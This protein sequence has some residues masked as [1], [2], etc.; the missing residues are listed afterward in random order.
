MQSLTFDRFLEARGLLERTEVNDVAN[1]FWDAH[2]NLRHGNSS[3][4]RDAEVLD[5]LSGDTC[6]ETEEGRVWMIVPSRWVR[7]WLLFAHL[8]IS[9]DAPGPINMDSLLQRDDS[10][11]GGWRPKNTLL[12][13]GKGAEAAEKAA[14]AAGIFDK[15]GDKSSSSN[16]SGGK[17]AS[18]EDFPG[19]Y[20]RISLEAWVQLVDLYGVT[21]PGFGLA[22]VSFLR[23]TEKYFT[24]TL[25]FLSYTSHRLSFLHWVFLLLAAWHTLPRL[26]KVGRL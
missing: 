17:E 23:Y 2:G 19:H 3:R 20:R 8:K 6:E 14:R 24:H 15:K 4:D 12:P 9:T 22:V 1:I 11:E 25:P 21:D 18:S 26:K 13:P 16:K 5:I 10:V 7:H